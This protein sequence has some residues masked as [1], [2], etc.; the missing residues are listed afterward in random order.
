L[1]V[2]AEDNGWFVSGCLL[3]KPADGMEAAGPMVSRRGND[4]R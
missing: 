2:Q 4:R 3:K 1:Y